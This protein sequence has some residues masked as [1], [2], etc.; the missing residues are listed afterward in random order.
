MGCHGFVT[1][2][3]AVIADHPDVSAGNRTDA[4]ERFVARRAGARYGAP[5]DPVVSQC[6]AVPGA[7]ASSAS[8]AI[9]AIPA[10]TCLRNRSTAAT[11][12][13]EWAFSGGMRAGL[14]DT[15]SAHALMP[16]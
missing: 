3:G 15:R 6:T 7:Y 5:G 11:S 12:A 13:V 14:S 9:R 8:S 1:D 16:R 2:S 4:P 10:P